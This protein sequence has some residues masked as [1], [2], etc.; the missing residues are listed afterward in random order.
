M[1]NSDIF[2]LSSILQAFMFDS[3]DDDSW[4]KATFIFFRKQQSITSTQYLMRGALAV[5][6]SM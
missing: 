4:T 3:F 6:H 5:D 1:W 2:V